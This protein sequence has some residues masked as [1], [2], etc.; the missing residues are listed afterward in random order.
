M[1][2]HS[3]ECDAKLKDLTSLEYDSQLRVDALLNISGAFFVL[4]GDLLKRYLDKMLRRV[5][6]L[7][8]QERVQC[9]LCE[10]GT[11]KG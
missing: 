2:K 8:L 7:A 5:G 11:S 6:E 9:G 1:A 10:R 3:K 4:W